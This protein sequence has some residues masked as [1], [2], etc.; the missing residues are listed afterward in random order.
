[1]NVY[2]YFHFLIGMYGFSYWSSWTPRDLR[3]GNNAT[4]SRKI[5]L[6]APPPKIHLGSGTEV[7][8][9][10]LRQNTASGYHLRVLTPE[11]LDLKVSGS[12]L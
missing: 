9:N 1:M 2:F 8:A 6:S 5:P 10:S 3:T 11:C 7:Q 12:E 4:S